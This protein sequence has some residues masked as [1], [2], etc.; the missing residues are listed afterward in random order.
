MFLAQFKS[1][2]KAFIN[3]FLSER[4]IPNINFPL[5]NLPWMTHEGAVAPYM[6]SVD[7]AKTFL[8]HAAL[9]KMKTREQV[10]KWASTK[11]DGY[12]APE[13]EYLMGG[14]FAPTGNILEYSEM[15]VDS[16][17]EEDGEPVPINTRP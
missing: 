15:D 14:D 1:L 8:E 7:D 9:V 5:E 2:K 12:R 16:D 11:F 10:T 13:V 3:S 17:S 6:F 4:L